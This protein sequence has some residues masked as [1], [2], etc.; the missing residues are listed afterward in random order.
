MGAAA[1]SR[2]PG[3]GALPVGGGCGAPRGVLPVEVTFDGAPAGALQVWEDAGVCRRPPHPERCLGIDPLE[4][5]SCD[6]HPLPS[7]ANGVPT[8]RG[9]QK[10]TSLVQLWRRPLSPQ[11][12]PQLN[13]TYIFR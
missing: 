10:Q 7:R 4:D 12:D 9:R 1:A 5:H 8:G 11:G 2:V 13:C 3:A 6:V